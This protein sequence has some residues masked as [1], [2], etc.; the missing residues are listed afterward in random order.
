MCEKEDIVSVNV[1]SCLW[2][3]H[4]SY[5]RLSFALQCAASVIPTCKCLL[6]I[7]FSTNQTQTKY[8]PLL[9]SLKR[10][11][12]HGRVSPSTRRSHSP[13]GCSLRSRSVP[14][15]LSQNKNG[16]LVIHFS[17]NQTQNTHTGHVS[18]S[19]K[20]HSP[21]GCSPFSRKCVHALAPPSYLFL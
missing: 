19:E 2:W 12:T 15:K 18:P 11:L 7:H 20:H 17:T 10:A 4:H 1:H 9:S 3:K 21:Q 6:G 16:C 5:E 8:L 13:Q 14:P